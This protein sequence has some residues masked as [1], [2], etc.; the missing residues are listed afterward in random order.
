MGAIYDRSNVASDLEQAAKTNELL[1]NKVQ[2]LPNLSS[3]AK[4][5]TYTF[6]NSLLVTPL[7]TRFVETPTSV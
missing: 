4:T 3:A 7:T 6:T 5:F 1:L 2:R